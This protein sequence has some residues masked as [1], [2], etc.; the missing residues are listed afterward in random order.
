MT[1][2]APEFAVTSSDF[3]IRDPNANSDKV[4][5][6]TEKDRHIEDDTPITYHYL[7]F[8]TG[9]P[10][11]TILAF[12]DSNALPP[13][14]PPDLRNHVS[15]FTWSAS[16]KRW[17]T[18][19]SCAVTVVTA[20]TAGSYSSA[21]AAMSEEWGVSEEA[22]YVGITTFTT[23]FA[24]APMVLAPFSEINGRYPVFVATGVG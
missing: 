10:S 5:V 3:G 9:L 20:Y 24:I 22:I 11:P 1:N 4:N 7:T 13:P 8:E 17:T 2:P 19:L 18:W 15:P 23:G 12:S 6:G 21:T 16:R 14:E